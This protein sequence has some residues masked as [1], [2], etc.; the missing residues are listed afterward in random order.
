[1]VSIGKI[2]GW[3]GVLQSVSRVYDCDL[4][5]HRCIDFLV[6]PTGMLQV[7]QVQKQTEKTLGQ[8]PRQAETR[9]LRPGAVHTPRID[10]L[11]ISDHHKLL[12]D[13][14]E[15]ATQALAA[16]SGHGMGSSRFLTSLAIV[17]WSTFPF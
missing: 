3:F 13:A 11:S 7:L 1:M 10:A 5:V 6:Q 17:V 4:S 8:K 16:V 9:G 15:T 2:A 12:G 14:V